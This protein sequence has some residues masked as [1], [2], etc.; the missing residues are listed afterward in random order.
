MERDKPIP[1]SNLHAGVLFRANE[2]NTSLAIPQYFQKMGDSNIAINT[3]SHM[4]TPPEIQLWEIMDSILTGLWIQYW[5][6]ALGSLH[7]NF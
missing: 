5:K 2:M 6:N 1:N 4:D 3:G 7:L